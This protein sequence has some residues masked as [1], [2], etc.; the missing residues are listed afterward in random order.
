MW[1]AWYNEYN[2][3]PLARGIVHPGNPRGPPEGGE[4]QCRGNLEHF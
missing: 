2:G 3:V 4:I 1:L